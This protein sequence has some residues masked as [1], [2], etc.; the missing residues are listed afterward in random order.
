MH[1]IMGFKP[2]PNCGYFHDFALSGV[3]PLQYLQHAVNCAQPFGLVG[4][5]WGMHVSQIVVI[6]SYAKKAF[7]WLEYLAGSTIDYIFESPYDMSYSSYAKELDAARFRLALVTFPNIFRRGGWVPLAAA[8]YHFIIR[9]I[10]MLSRH[11]EVRTSIDKWLWVTSR[12]VKPAC[13]SSASSSSKRSKAAADAKTSVIPRVAT[14]KTPAARLL[15]TPSANE[16]A[17]ALLARAA[18]K[19]AVEPDGAVLYRAFFSF[20]LPVLFL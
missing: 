17:K 9:E 13:S 1:K 12:F 10:S 4:I 20:H 6:C 18:K 19:A 5:W 8:H 11:A 7:G 16:V 2:P 15:E 3:T 14:L